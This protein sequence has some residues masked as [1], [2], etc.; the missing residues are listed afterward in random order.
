MTIG[1]KAKKSRDRGI[2]PHPNRKLPTYAKLPKR[3][4]G[5]ACPLFSDGKHRIQVAP[6]GVRHPCMCGA[7]R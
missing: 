1:T 7:L 5:T 4:P 3:R 6:N 2:D